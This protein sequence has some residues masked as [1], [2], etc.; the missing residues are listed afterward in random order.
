[1][2]CHREE[3]FLFRKYDMAISSLSSIIF[4]SG[5]EKKPG[6]GREL[7]RHFTNGLAKTTIKPVF[8]KCKIWLQLLRKEV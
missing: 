8:F 2:R 4:L 5:E 3:S 6:G 7:P 1:M